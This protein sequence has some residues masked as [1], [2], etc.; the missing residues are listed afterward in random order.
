MLHLLTHV[1]SQHEFY[2]YPP[3]TAVDR[4]F[5]TIKP[6]GYV[7]DNSKGVA[8]SHTTPYDAIVDSGTTLLYVP[9]PVADG[10]LASFNPPATLYEGDYFYPCDATAPYFGITIAGTIFNISSADIIL[11]DSG[12]TNSTSGVDYCLIGVIDGGNGIDAMPIFGDVFLKNVVAV[13]DVGASLLA[14]AQHDY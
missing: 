10:Y 3:V 13:F 2:A 1:L 8:T 5:Y 7:Y 6:D 9:T 4:S 14:F 12:Y 11:P